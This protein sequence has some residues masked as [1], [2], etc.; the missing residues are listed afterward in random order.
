MSRRI[1]SGVLHYA[2][3]AGAFGLLLAI[4]WLL[5]RAGI[6][7]DVTTTAMI[8]L[9]IGAAWFGGFGPGILVALLFEAAIGYFSPVGIH[10][11]RQ[12]VP[13]A[14]NRLLLFSAVVWFASSRRAAELRLRRHRAT[15]QESLERE[16]AAREEAERANRLKDDFLATVS[17]ELRTPLN[18]IAGWASMLGRGALDRESAS[19]AVDAIERS[20]K[21]QA[22][23]VD[24]L[25][26]ASALAGGRL[27]IAQQRLSLAAVVEEA[28]ETMRVAGSARGI[29]FEVHVD[30]AVEVLG[31]PDRLRQ[32]SWNL[33]AN[34][35]KFNAAG[36]RVEVRVSGDTERAR[37][38]VRN[39]GPGI[40]PEFLPFVFEPFRQGDASMTREHGGLGLGLAIVRQLVELHGGSVSA[41]SEGEG[42]GALFTVEIPLATGSRSPRSRARETNVSAV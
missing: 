20:A 34:A 32:I 28:L 40:T 37:L 33:I 23:I 8:L 35:I 27:H 39:T 7:T 10:H 6:T 17:H 42:H 16:H 24:D 2:A 12:Y 41:E 3:A 15:L 19:R 38:S 29:D 26:D 21:T 9:L 14:I 13:V 25:L 31:D 22:R 4:G 18:V 11:P 5:R 36:G 1:W 30:R